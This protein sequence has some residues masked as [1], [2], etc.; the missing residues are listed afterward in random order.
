MSIKYMG[1]GPA[2]R[3]ARVFINAILFPFQ[4]TGNITLGGLQP[5]VVVNVFIAP[6]SGGIGVT[7][8]NL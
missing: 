8:Q 6:P 5:K 4:T 2:L 7:G 1:A 3:R